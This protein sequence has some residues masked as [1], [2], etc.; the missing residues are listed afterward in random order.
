MYDSMI[1]QPNLIPHADMDAL[2]NAPVE[3]ITSRRTGTTTIAIN[4]L[5]DTTDCHEAIDLVITHIAH[6]SP[7]TSIRN[8]AQIGAVIKDKDRRDLLTGHVDDLLIT[9]S[10]KIGVAKQSLLSN[11][12]TPESIFKLFKALFTVIMDVFDQQL[13]KDCKVGTFKQL[14]DQLLL[15]MTEPKIAA[16]PDGDQL[17]KA[18][19]M[20]TLKLL[21]LSTQTTSYCALI[22][23]LNEKTFDSR[24]QSTTAAPSAKYLELVMKCIWRQIRSLS[25]AE[26]NTADNINAAPVLVEINA[27][28][29]NFPSSSWASRGSNESSSKDLPLRTVKTLL[30]HLAKSRGE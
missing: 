17:V 22:R 2:L 15:I 18:V 1:T 11:M 27:F 30:Y 19:N 16:F 21:A 14:I 9:C 6:I 13:A 28:L 25:N 26:R 5:R 24:A 4:M 8:L 29:R 10:T 3:Q 12:D 20:V 23:L 7:E